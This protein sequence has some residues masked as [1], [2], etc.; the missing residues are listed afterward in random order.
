MATAEVKRTN[1]RATK[2]E[3]RPER[4]IALWA[5]ES[6]T[7]K[8]FAVANL[9]NALIFDT[10]IGGGLAYLDARIKRNGSERVEVGSYLDVMEHLQ[11]R[12]RQ[13]GE[14]T[15]LA[16]DHLT[17]LQQESVLR[18]NP[19]ALDDFGRSYDKATREWRKLREFVRQ[20][21][22]HLVCTAHLKSKYVNNKVAG[23]TSDASKNIEADF[24]MV[25]YLEKGNS[26]PSTARVMKWR[27]DPEDER[28]VVPS[29]FPF[30]LE[31]FVELHGCPLEGERH[32]V[33]LATPEQLAELRNLLSIV[34]V[35]DDWEEKCLTKAKAES[36]EEVPE[37][38][39][40]RCIA[41]L[42]EKLPK[43]EQPAF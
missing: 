21:D 28:G 40:G 39:I 22:F 34:K 5:G 37:E 27:R 17:T 9:R 41:Y 10:D 20:G 11:K 33:A 14:I 13:M 19:Q 25:L 42:D 31:K 1:N 24:T 16:F 12:R 7:G 32:E 35:P 6:G 8:S 18:H 38:S 36:W 43:K 30:T 4:V 3:P 26:Y 23:I 29:S 15:T 2:Q